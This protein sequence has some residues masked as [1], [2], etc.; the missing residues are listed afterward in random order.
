[1]SEDA[2]NTRRRVGILGG[3]FD[4]IHRGHVDMCLAAEGALDLSRI[5]VIPSNVPPHRAQT[6]ASAFHRFAM[7]ASAIADHQA[8]RA[9]D[10]ELRHAGTSFTADTLRKFHERGYAPADLFFIIGADAFTEIATWR[11]Y[12]R[13]LDRTHFAVVSRPGHPSGALPY[14]LPDLGSRMVSPPLEALAVMDPSIV[15]IDAPTANVSSTAI[16]QRCAEGQS[17]AGLV[18]SRVQ[19][20]IEQH[21]LYAATNRRRID[22]STQ[23]PAEPLHG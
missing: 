21:G 5:F 6:H 17:L 18:S 11:D 4:P 19:A 16:R 2:R 9:S 8:W 15:L 13:I 14:T 22:Q 3:T 23:P 10:L 1:M 20:H 7:V 12:P